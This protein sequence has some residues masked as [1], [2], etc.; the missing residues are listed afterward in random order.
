[1]TFDHTP[2]YNLKVVLQETGLAADTLRAWERRY[3][4]PVP[5]RTAGR[6]RLYSQYDIETVKWLMA[7][8]AEGLSISRAVEIWKEKFASGADPLAAPQQQ[9]LTL[10]PAH[11][12]ETAR[13]NWIAACCRFDAPAAEQIL[14][15]AFA[16]N[17]IE[18]ACSEVIQRGLFEIGERWYKGDV[19]VQQEHFA[20]E[21]AVRRLEALI[22]ATP[23]PIH[24]ETIVTACP[25]GEWHS[26]PL[27]LLTLLLR[28]R[29]W[30]VVALGANVPA[31]QM[32]EA[33]KVI[34]P[35]LVILSAQTLI[36]AVSLRDLAGI[37]NKKYSV[38]FGGRVFNA[39]SDLRNRIPAHYLGT[40]IET[41]VPRIES[42][43]RESASMPKETSADNKTLNTAMEFK[44]ARPLIETKISETLK[45]QGANYLDTANHFFGDSLTA[46]LELGSV[47]YVSTELKWLVNLLVEHQTPLAL[48]PAYLDIYAKAVRS[49]MKENGKPIIDWLGL[50]SQKLKA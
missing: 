2:V 16:A 17:S 12:L 3:S 41:T 10:P 48:L 50:E 9:A 44:Q 31:E 20:S 24:A 1:M 39:F 19:S 42:L 22:N 32:E 28:R 45:P 23:P 30:N 7:R 46:A 11:S 13:E 21:I 25:A 34:H 18:I 15:Q 14:N 35:K 36:T 4:L 33:L 47:S 37:L 27:L 6:H 49:I 29:G 40:T 43:I 38:A 26:F 8:Q 5:Q